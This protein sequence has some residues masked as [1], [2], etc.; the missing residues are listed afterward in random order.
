M[1]KLRELLSYDKC[2]GFLTWKPRAG[3]ESFNKRFAGKLDLH[4][5]DGKGYRCGKLMRKDV[6]AHRV[7]WALVHGEEPEEIDH[8]NG[9]KL[10][11]RLCNLRSV[12]HGENLKNRPIY[13]NN[14]SGFTGVYF[15]ARDL[16]WIAQ[17]KANGRRMHVGRFNCVTAAAV[18]R[19][20]AEAEFGYH[21]NHG[22][23]K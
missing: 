13:S 16:K 1:S 8:I 11:N 15:Y 23:Q 19:K 18:A 3:N 6:L 14:K 20:I 10:D 9:D 2:T 4:C 12:T 17:I 7:I 21:E 5:I 22:R